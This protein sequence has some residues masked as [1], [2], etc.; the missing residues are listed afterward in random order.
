MTAETLIHVDF[1]PHGGIQNQIREALVAAILEGRL[2]SGMRLPSSRRLAQ[3]LNV[4]RNTVVLVYESLAADGYLHSRERSGYFVNDGMQVERAHVRARPPSEMLQGPDWAH[5]FRLRPSAQANIEKPAD[6]HAYAYPF[7]YGQVDP[8]L[9]PVQAWRKCTQLAMNR[10][11]LADWTRDSFGEDE[12]L[13]VRQIRERLLPRRGIFVTDEEVLITNG[14]QNAL[15]LISQLLVNERSTVAF[16]DPGYPDMRNIFALSTPRLMK[17]PVDAQGLPVDERLAQCDYLYVTPSH[18]FPTTVT[19][20]LA[21]RSALIDMAVRHRFL[22]IED[23]Y[24]SET[25]YLSEKPVPALKSL[26]R[27]NRVIHVGSLSKSLFPGL[28]LGYLVGPA[29]FIAEARAL[30]RLVLRHPPN[31]SQRITA[32]F[33]RQGFHD[34][35]TRKLHTVYRERWC[36]LGAALDRFLPNSATPPSFGGTA[37]WVRGPDGLDSAGLADAARSEGVLIEP[38]AVHFA[39]PDGPRNYFRLGFS[40]IATERIEPGMEKLARLIERIS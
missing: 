16:E 3:D 13:L 40:A 25:N 20:P 37:F 5:R 9:F 33:L 7:I 19:L 35:F 31:L 2:P 11:E 10:G 29:E 32:L 22:I 27:Q 17:V 18:Q 39:D 24:E 26:D 36:R 4:S 14:A 12:Q 30:R 15:Y 28:R 34:A 21:R 1:R 8:N 38:G 6:W 23:D